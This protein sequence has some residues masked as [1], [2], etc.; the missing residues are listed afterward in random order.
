M[1]APGAAPSSTHGHGSSEV[2]TDG[3]AP[4]KND[5]SAGTF[6]VP[7]SI[8][9]LRNNSA[10]H[11]S[12]AGAS[13]PSSASGGRANASAKQQEAP[14]LTTPASG[15][16]RKAAFVYEPPPWGLGGEFTATEEAVEQACAHPAFPDLMLEVIRE[17]VVIDQVPLKGR[18]WWLLGS[19]KEHVDVLYEHPFVSRRHLA[20]QFAA[21]PPFNLYCIDLQSSY[22]TICNGVPLKPHEPFLV[23]EATQAN[24]GTA[25]ASEASASIPDPPA[26][27]ADSSANEDEANAGNAEASEQESVFFVGGRGNTRRLFVIKKRTDEPAIPVE[28]A[29]DKTT[30]RNAS[31]GVGK[32]KPSHS[33][34]IEEQ[35]KTASSESKG[36][37]SARG[38]SDG[39]KKLQDTRDMPKTGKLAMSAQGKPGATCPPQQQSP[40]GG[41]MDEEKA[42]AESPTILEG[43]KGE[44]FLE[45]LQKAREK[46]RKAGGAQP[47]DVPE[48]KNRKFAGKEKD[49][50]TTC[51][52]DEDEETPEERERRER[53]EAN[54]EAMM[55]DEDDD[56]FDRSAGAEG[57]AAAQKRKNKNQEPLTEASLERRMAELKREIA[58]C[59]A[60]MERIAK[61]HSEKTQPGTQ[62]SPSAAGSKAKPAKAAD[63]FDDGMDSLDAFMAGVEQSLVSQ[64]R[65]KVE[66]R[67]KT[68][69]AELKETKRLLALAKA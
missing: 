3:R 10:S 4:C 68:L 54:T 66:M 42:L 47:V 51:L 69:K 37:G 7:A 46:K 31:Q 30:Q 62:A 1:Q 5:S 28:A 44:A 20:L 2:R 49:S 55:F 9:T 39:G 67:M 50:E 53:L 59:N 29:A 52:D 27:S 14:P 18:G 60:E 36:V 35:M 16:D 13:A 12:G 56:F 57:A 32:R 43:E 38:K 11:S 15:I 21:K 34:A 63:N 33:V 23:Y 24:S 22:G 64:E 17:G 8:R 45:E 6:A 19:L 61:T 41:E 65:E 26:C 40:E 48:M 58:R 25:G